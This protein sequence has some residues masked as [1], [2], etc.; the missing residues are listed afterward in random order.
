MWKIDTNLKL[1]NNHTA[2]T[3][4]YPWGLQEIGPNSGTFYIK[5]KDCNPPPA[6]WYS[7]PKTPA[8]TNDKTKVATSPIIVSSK[9][10]PPAL[11][12]RDPNG[13]TKKRTPSI[14]D[15]SKGVPGVPGVP[16]PREKR[17]VVGCRT[18][19]FSE[20]DNKIIEKEFLKANDPQQMW[21]MT[22]PDQG[23]FFK[24]F[25]EGKKETKSEKGKEK[26]KDTNTYVSATD[27]P[28]VLFESKQDCSSIIATNVANFRDFEKSTRK[29]LT[30]LLGFFVATIV[31]RWWD[32]TSKI[33][34]LDKLAMALNV[35]MQEGIYKKKS[36]YTKY[37]H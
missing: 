25:M 32:Q 19:T 8:T 22:K 1:I 23:G 4:T 6:K 33:P 2:N 27:K 31:K 12:P 36:D 26:P 16:G 9:E 11:E 7:I 10:I 15:S 34:R 21:N 3:E 30:I 17:A 13:G 20:I 37:I 14:I 18:L 5:K 29:V 35:I 24:L 28:N